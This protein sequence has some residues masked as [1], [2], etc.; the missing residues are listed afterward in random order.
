MFFLLI[1]FQLTADIHLQDLQDAGGAR[2]LGS[3]ALTTE[4]EAGGAVNRQPHSSEALDGK[5]G[6]GQN[7]THTCTSVS[8]DTD[9]S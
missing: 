5:C 1:T 4:T 8:E 3:V 6:Q 7:A 9:K 2:Q